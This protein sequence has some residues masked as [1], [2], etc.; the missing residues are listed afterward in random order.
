MAGIELLTPIIQLLLDF[1]QLVLHI[2]ADLL[3]LHLDILKDRRTS[4]LGRHCCRGASV[5][6]WYDGYC[7]GNGLDGLGTDSSSRQR[8][9]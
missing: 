6:D 7:D 3:C 1:L 9:R 8:G 5:G 4:R 2:L